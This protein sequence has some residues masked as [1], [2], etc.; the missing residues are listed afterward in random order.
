MIR[1]GRH[2]TPMPAFAHESGGSL[3]DA[4]IKVLADGNQIAL[5]SEDATCRNAAPVCADSGRT[6]RPCAERR[7][8]RR[9]SLSAPVPVAMA[10]NGGGGSANRNERRRD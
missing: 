2:G 1:D 3:T 4:Q 6:A 8:R 9:R 5:E 10:P 7:S